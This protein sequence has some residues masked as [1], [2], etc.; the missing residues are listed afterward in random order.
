LRETSEVVDSAAPFRG[1]FF[2]I[3][4]DLSRDR[5]SVN[6]GV[7]W[8]QEDYDDGSTTDR[9][10][11]HVTLRVRRNISQ[12]VFAGFGYQYRR[13]DFI[14]LG[15][16]DD[17]KQVSAE[18]GYRFGPASSVSL[19]YVHFDR[20]GDDAFSIATENRLFLRYFYSPAW[21]R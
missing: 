5:T 15:I 13:R 11:T 18:I 19:Q 10:T 20:S 2:S 6:V 4:Y 8:I 9:D 7:N 1:N 16:V 17:D 14:E 21:G 12:S 3:L